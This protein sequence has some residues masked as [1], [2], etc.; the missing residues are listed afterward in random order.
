[1]LLVLRLLDRPSCEPDDTTLEN[2]CEPL[3]GVPDANLEIL[4]MSKVSLFGADKQ[5]DRTAPWLP[6]CG[7]PA[8][9]ASVTASLSPL[10]LDTIGRV[11][12]SVRLGTVRG[13]ARPGCHCQ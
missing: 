10:A 4:G 3:N 11:V 9:T 8:V 5:Q 7:A 2:R 12:V 6:M 13:T 1:M